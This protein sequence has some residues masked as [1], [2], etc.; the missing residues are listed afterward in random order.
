MTSQARSQSTLPI[1]TLALLAVGIILCINFVIWGGVPH[2]EMV[3]PFWI[4]VG[5]LIA[6]CIGFGLLTWHLL[7]RPLPAGHRL[8]AATAA[9]A[10][11]RQL[12]AMLLGIAAIYL[13]VGGFWDEIWH[14]QYGLPFGEDFFWRPHIMM[15]FCFGAVVL[16]GMYSLYQLMKGGQ[17]T[18]QQRFRANPI[19]GLVVLTAAFLFFALPVDPIWHS[20]YGEDISAW[21]IPHLLLFFAFAGVMLLAMALQLSTLPLRPWRGPWR[22]GPGDLVPLLM[23]AAIVLTMG[24]LMMTEWDN[25][26]S[27]TPLMRSRPE[28]LLP[29]VI[30]GLV[31]VSGALINH[32]LRCAGAATTTVLMALGTRLLLMRLFETDIMS[33][34][35]WLLMLAPALA[36]DLWHGLRTG[37]NGSATLWLG[38]GLACALGTLVVAYP[39]GQL[40][41]PVFRIQNLPVMV[42]VVVL[43]GIG[44][45]WLGTRLGEYLSTANKFVDPAPVGLSTQVISLGGLLASLALIV[46]LVVTAAPPL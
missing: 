36:L 35:A 5:V 43:I 10:S 34:N 9:P 24:Q 31:A 44:A 8:P 19:L 23:N 1:R 27:L 28:W 14:R 7:F 40:L 41:Y 29:A 12:I 15:Y 42:V 33:A 16:L 22:L 30:V 3:T 37:E 26:N 25:T 39:L 2:G 18:F 21:S 17:G 4:G 20:I 11:I 38:S 46:V 32:A 13:V 45:A 6:I